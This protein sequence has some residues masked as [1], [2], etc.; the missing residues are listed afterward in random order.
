[1]KEVELKQSTKQLGLRMEVVHF[2]LSNGRD[3]SIFS[4]AERP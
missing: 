2:F 3:W 1:M 4:M